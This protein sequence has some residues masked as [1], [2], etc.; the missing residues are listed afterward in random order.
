MLYCPGHESRPSLVGARFA[1]VL[2]GSVNGGLRLTAQ[3]G[4]RIY[5]GVLFTGP[6]AVRMQRVSISAAASSGSS[7]AA[8]EATNGSSEMKERE[9]AAKR[10]KPAVSSSSATGNEVSSSTAAA[11]QHIARPA[12]DDNPVQ[13]P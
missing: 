5:R 9:Q 8:L 1:A 6:A 3:L 10:H 13:P 2:D 4:D 12:S 11:Q 7:S